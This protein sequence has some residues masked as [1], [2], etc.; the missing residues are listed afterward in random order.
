MTR[1]DRVKSMGGLLDPTNIRTL[2]DI[3]EE[4][5]KDVI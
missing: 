2:D 5:G 4:Y 3:C 1:A